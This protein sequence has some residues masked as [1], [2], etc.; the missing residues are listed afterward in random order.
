MNIKVGIRRRRIMNKIVATSLLFLLLVGCSNEEEATTTIND[1]QVPVSGSIVINDKEYDMQVGKYHWSGGKGE[2][3]TKVDK[4]SPNEV[5]KRFDDL[6]VEK[7]TKMKVKIRN[8]PKLTVYQRTKSNQKQKVTLT[9]NNIEAP[10][11]SGYYLYEVYGKW[12]HG[13][14]TYVFDVNVE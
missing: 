8:N 14:A 9:D 5:A 4:Y 2:K 10:L 13:K 1:K 3:I 12:S 11:N 7:G 6:T